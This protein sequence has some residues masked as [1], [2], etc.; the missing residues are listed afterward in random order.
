MEDE[1]KTGVFKW[2]F[3]VITGSTTMTDRTKACNNNCSLLFGEIRTTGAQYVARTLKMAEGKRKTVY[4]LGMGHGKHL[5][6]D[7]LEYENIVKAVG[8][9]FSSGRFEAARTNLQNYANSDKN[10]KWLMRDDKNSCS[11]KHYIMSKKKIKKERT[12][13]FINGDMRNVENINEADIVLLL[14]AFSYS[15][16]IKLVTLLAELKP[17]AKVCSYQSLGGDSFPFKSIQ[18]DG[19][20]GSWSSG[21]GLHYY[22]RLPEG[23]V[24]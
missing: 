16:E 5:L 8:I 10:V 3:P 21:E 17:G 18:H 2:K 4:D 22:E 23:E 7:F 9:E 15:V 14:T 13:K 11:I 20:Y 1:S 19:S 24:R 6:Q 12:L